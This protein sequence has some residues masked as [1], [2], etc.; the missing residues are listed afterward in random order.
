MGNNR[1]IHLLKCPICSRKMSLE[2]AQRH[3]NAKHRNLGWTEFQHKLVL[4]VR[5]GKIKVRTVQARKVKVR[6]RFWQASP[7]LVSGTQRIQTSR[8]FNKRIRSVV[9]GGRVS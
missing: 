7:S 4:A 8:M 5:T 6:R 1:S 3:Q 9:S 2:N